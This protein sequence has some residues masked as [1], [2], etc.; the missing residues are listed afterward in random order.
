MVVSAQT[1]AE[2]ELV[3]IAVTLTAPP[4]PDQKL[5][6]ESL[7][8]VPRRAPTGHRQA[9]WEISRG[10]RRSSRSNRFKPFNAG[11]SGQA[12]IQSVAPGMPVL[13]HV[14]PVDSLAD[15]ATAAARAGVDVRP[16]DLPRDVGFIAAVA[17]SCAAFARAGDGAGPASTNVL[18]ECATTPGRSVHGWLARTPARPEGEAIGLVT[19]VV[20]GAG[21]GPPRASIGWL[22]V[23]PTHRRRGVATAL[24]AR[25]ADH[26]RSLGIDRIVADTL[27]QWPAATGFWGSIATPS[28]G[29]TGM[30]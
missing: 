20:V 5:A 3:A 23:A 6:C 15:A 7:R 26:A 29:R 14:F 16:V 18:A 21:A 13:H 27:A 1:R 22:L 30:A 28:S 11:G 9:V 19:L 24:V 17:A 10:I 2:P 12:L 25:A 8:G 4:R